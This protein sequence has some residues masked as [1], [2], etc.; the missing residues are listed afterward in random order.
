LDIVAAHQHFDPTEPIRNIA[1][2]LELFDH[3]LDDT[4]R[5]EV[6]S[7]VRPTDDVAE[8]RRGRWAF[9]IDE[10]QTFVDVNNTM[11]GRDSC[12]DARPIATEADKP[13]LHS[14]EV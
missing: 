11:L 4:D 8:R 7:V 6:H 5:T 3:F 13:H 1:A 9:V 14:S 2:R 12:M 10:C